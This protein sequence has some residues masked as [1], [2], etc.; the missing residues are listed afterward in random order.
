MKNKSGVI[1]I[2]GHVQG[3]ANTRALGE[4]GI[5][6][7][8]VDVHSCVAASSKFCQDFYTCPPFIEDSFADFLIDL[9][10]DQNLQGWLLLPSNDHA[11]YTLSKHKEKLKKFYKFLVPDFKELDKI[12]DKV[13]LL[14]LAK[15]LLVPIPKTF[16]INE[17]T[18][19]EELN[20]AYPVL[21]RGRNGLSFYKKVGR[22][23][24]VSKSGIELKRDL[25][26]ISEKT[27]LET[28]FTQEFIPF[29][30]TNKTISFTAFCIGGEIKCF[31]MGVKLRE[32]PLQVGTAT[33][34]ESIYIDECLKQSIILLRALNYEGICE[35]EYLKDPRVNQYKLIEINP[36]TWLWVGHAI[37]SGVN[38]P[39]LAYNYVNGIENQ[40][41][42]KYNLGL[43]WR[44]PI[45]DLLFSLLAIVEGKLSLKQY[46]IYNQ[47][48]VVNSLWYKGDLKPFFRY[49]ALMLKFLKNR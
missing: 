9:A 14:D 17:K 45:S 18:K 13:K 41:P 30:G 34:T 2:E 38:Y 29:D 25:N 33:F 15:K 21:T 22:I 11:V 1:I 31:W 36:R 43:K 8:V 19:V 24:F 49:A 40:Y 39:L 26:L 35:V 37:A 42:V 12:Y 6:V 48:P 27:N 5:P 28:A 47:G 4:Q 3:L 20:L 16:C 7:V 32:H 44:N 23:G 46:M 10:Q